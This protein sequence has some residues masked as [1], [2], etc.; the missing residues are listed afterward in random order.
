[1]KK[2]LLYF[3]VLGMMCFISQP[4]NAAKTKDMYLIKSIKTTDNSRYSNYTYTKNGLVKKEEN[5]SSIIDYIYKNGYIAKEVEKYKEHN[6][7]FITK[8]TYKKGYLVKKVRKAPDG[9]WVW[10]YSRNKKGQII[11][12]TITGEEKFSNTYIYKNNR[13]RKAV[14]RDENMKGIYRYTYDKKGY[15]IKIDD[16]Y[17]FTKIK[18]IYK[19][20]R[21]VTKKF[22][23]KE[24]NAVKNDLGDTTSSLEYQ[25]LYVKKKVPRSKVAR[26]KD[27]Q[28]R[29]IDDQN[30]SNV[31]SK[32]NLQ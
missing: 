28:R 18:N 5:E 29:L 2:K 19:N 6:I 15:P 13:V 7:K 4:V 25:L 8:Q 10:K 20:G 11:K 30:S 14:Y 3:T 24:K 1:M 26:V 12:E 22:N 32:W 16:P 21:L 17:Y 27:Q 23:I 9:T 31:D